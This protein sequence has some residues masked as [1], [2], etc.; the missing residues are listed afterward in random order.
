LSVLIGCIGSSSSFSF[1][2]RKEK[3]IRANNNS[4]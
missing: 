3:K 4:F 2:S 1:L